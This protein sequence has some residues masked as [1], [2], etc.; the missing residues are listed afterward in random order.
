MKNHT[1]QNIIFF[2]ANKDDIDFLGARQLS[3]GPEL[4]TKQTNRATP[5]K[6][7]NGGS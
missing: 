5:A 4:S 6:R 1:R 2:N 7:T 3:T